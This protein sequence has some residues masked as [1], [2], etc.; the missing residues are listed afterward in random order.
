M[1]SDGSSVAWKSGSSFLGV[2][3]DEGVNYLR[4]GANNGLALT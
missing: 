1:S 4:V 2:L 3:A